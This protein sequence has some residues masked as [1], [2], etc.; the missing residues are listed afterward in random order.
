MLSTQAVEAEVSDTKIP[1]VD[2]LDIER[3]P[4]DQELEAIMQAMTESATTKWEAAWS[5]YQRELAAGIREAAK[6]GARS[7]KALRSQRK[8]SSPIRAALK[9]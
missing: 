3:E 9:R 5:K 7:A 2:L 8:A 6:V 4:T 1:K